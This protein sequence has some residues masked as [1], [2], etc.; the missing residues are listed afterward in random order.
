MTAYHPRLAAAAVAL[1]LL[2][3]GCVTTVSP[4]PR[5]ART[6]VSAPRTKPVQCVGIRESTRLQREVA[7]ANA[8]RLYFSKHQGRRVARHARASRFIAVQTVRNTDSTGEAT[9]MIFDRESGNLVGSMV[10]D[11]DRVPQV[12]QTV[13]F[14]TYNA[15]Y[16]GS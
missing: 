9:C 16:V 3:G 8:R 5:T 1:G 7:Q 12:G 2:C 4:P 10:Y 14:A 11:C 15:T 13:K 6:K